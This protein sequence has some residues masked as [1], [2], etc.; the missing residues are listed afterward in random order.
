MVNVAPEQRAWQGRHRRPR[1]DRSGSTHSVHFRPVL[2]EFVGVLCMAMGAFFLGFPTVSLFISG[3][4]DYFHARDV[5]TLLLGYGLGLVCVWIGIR[6]FRS[7]TH[8]S[9]RTREAAGSLTRCG[10][11]RF[12]A[13]V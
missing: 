2:R 13:P 12:A 11:L 10:S 5:R 1:R 8:A 6:Q 4:Y 9:S 7:Q 3:F